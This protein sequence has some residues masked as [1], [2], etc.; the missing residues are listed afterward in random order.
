[1]QPSRVRPGPQSHRQRRGLAQRNT[2]CHP[3]HRCVLVACRLFGVFDGLCCD[4]GLHS[5]RRRSSRPG[6]P[7]SVAWL[8]TTMSG[9]WGAWRVGWS[10]ACWGMCDAWLNT[11]TLVHAMGTRC[12]CTLCTLWV[13]DVFARMCCSSCL[14]PVVVQSCLSKSG[15]QGV[16]T[17][18][19]HHGGGL[20]LVRCRRRAVC[21]GSGQRRGAGH[22]CGGLHGGVFPARAR[23][24]GL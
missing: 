7:S 2:R 18:Q 12:V 22:Q 16:G 19:G 10:R 3:R 4:G 8:A 20:C 14:F 24:V 17:P 9:C 23:A 5:Q 15:V 6:G 13:H 1:M 21:D 11:Y